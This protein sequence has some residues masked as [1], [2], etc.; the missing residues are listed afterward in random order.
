MR[1]MYAGQVVE[2]GEVDDILQRPLHPYTAGLLASL[3][4]QGA[5]QSRLASIPGRV[6]SPS[7]MPQGCRFEPRCAHAEDA[8]RSKQA[9]LAAGER[10]I[11]CRRWDALNLSGAVA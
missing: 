4:R 11:R 6:P 7:E 1:T 9:L 8:C 2:G 10:R 3:P 5:H